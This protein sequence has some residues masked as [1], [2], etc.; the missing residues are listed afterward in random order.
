M[1][2]DDIS[3]PDPLIAVVAIEAQR[4]TAESDGAKP[5]HESDGAKPIHELQLHS[6]ALPSSGE[7]AEVA[8]GVDGDVQTCMSVCLSLCMHVCLFVCMC[9]RAYVVRVRYGRK[10]G[11]VYGSKK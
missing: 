8:D 5:I 2:V 7:T 6:V 1:L 10:G 3:A 4:Q 9:T 11:R